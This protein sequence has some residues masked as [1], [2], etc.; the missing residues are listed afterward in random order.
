M[1]V[2]LPKSI[3]FTSLLG[4]I[5][6]LKGSRNYAFGSPKII[7]FPLP[8]HL[9][10]YEKHKFYLGGSTILR[11][12]LTS[13]FPVFHCFCF[14]LSPLSFL[15]SLKLIL[16]VLGPGTSRIDSEPPKTMLLLRREHDSQKNMFFLVQVVET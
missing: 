1:F 16:A 15:G 7:E 3:D 2:M 12:L 10:S 6:G 13:S 9:V 5:I 8:R 11:D 4:Y 14:K